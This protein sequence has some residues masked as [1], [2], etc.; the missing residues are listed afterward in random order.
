MQMPAF[1]SA[2]S[3]APQ[4][5]QTRW[6]FLE[7]LRAIRLKPHLTFLNHEPETLRQGRMPR[8]ASTD[9]PPRQSTP[10]S[11][12]ARRNVS[13]REPSD[14]SVRSESAMPR[15]LHGGEN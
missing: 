15:P 3:V 14:P 9:N 8:P 10:T 1:Y 4:S 2:S 11:S 7:A 13:R 6:H 5:H 12:T